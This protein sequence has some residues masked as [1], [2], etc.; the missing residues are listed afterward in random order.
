MTRFFMV[1]HQ[2]ADKSRLACAVLKVVCAKCRIGETIQRERLPKSVPFKLGHVP[3]KLGHVP[4]RVIPKAAAVAGLLYLLAPPAFAQ[5]DPG[6]RGGLLNTAASL[7][8]T[9]IQIPPPPATTPH[10]PPRPPH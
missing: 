9:A 4:S 5:T 3:S 7:E 6:V 10:P 8:Y 2:P 1:R